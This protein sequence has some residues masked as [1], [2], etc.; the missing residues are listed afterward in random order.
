MGMLL[1]RLPVIGCQWSGILG[2][3]ISPLERTYELRQQQL[4]RRS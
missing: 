2:K 4:V 3:N 1:V